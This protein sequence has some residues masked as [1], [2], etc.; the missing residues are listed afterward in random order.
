[1]LG[2]PSGI[3]ADHPTKILGEGWDSGCSSPPEFWGR[4]GVTGILNIRGEEE[5][6]KQYIE[7]NCLDITDHENC[8]AGGTNPPTPCTSEYAPYGLFTWYTDYLT[9]K[10]L[11]IHG[12]SIYGIIA[13]GASNWTVEDSVIKNNG[14]AGWNGDSVAIGSTWGP[15]GD[16]GYINFTRSNV[17]FNGCGETYPGL[18]TIDCW[19]QQD[20]RAGYGDGI[21]FGDGTMANWTF[22]DSSV[23][24]N[25][26]DGFDGLHGD[27]SGSTTAIRSKFAGNAGN[28][29]KS[30]N[31]LNIEDSVIIGDGGFMAGQPFADAA[32]PYC[33]AGGQ[34]LVVPMATGRIHKIINS[35]ILS[36]CSI[37]FM[38]TGTCGDGSSLFLR[39]NIFL[40]GRNFL[41]D[42]SNPYSGADPDDSLSDFFYDA[43]GGC[44][45]QGTAVDED[46]NIFYGMKGGASDV[47]GA[48]S[49]YYDPGFSGTIQLGP[50]DGAG[51][52]A[53]SDAENELYLA[54]G[55]TAIDASDETV[56]CVGDCSVDYNSY[57][58]GASW[59]IGA[60]EYGSTPE[61]TPTPTPSPSSQ[62][63]GQLK[64]VSFFGVIFQ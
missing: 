61:S 10:N 37:M 20:P 4:K 15:V 55:S 13:N 45:N 53:Q 63:E 21:G 60:L 49:V 44:P 43:Y 5:S 12:L 58:R 23:S 41:A 25:T 2:I 3:D 54:E 11:N 31:P 33:R 19:G 24:Y 47:E 51:Y 9:L 59:D 35:T 8:Q 52:F 38:T 29:I 42:S 1:M 40:G 6:H 56:D 32:V 17:D 46:Y 18:E 30:T 50:Y 64:G 36:S 48:N 7:I 28:Q 34:A 62:S 57:D 22:T 14:F 16:S 39:N 26:S 27:G